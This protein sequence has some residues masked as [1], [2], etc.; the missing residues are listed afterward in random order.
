M[1]TEQIHAKSV[2]AAIP[3]TVAARIRELL[4]QARDAYG[5]DDWD[6]DDCESRVLDLVTE[7][8]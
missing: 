4:D 6:G 8:S 3:F 1:T 2:Q 7:D 5:H